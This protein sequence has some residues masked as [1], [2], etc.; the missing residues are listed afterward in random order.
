[1]SEYQHAFQI[2]RLIGADREPGQLVK[3]VREKPFAVLLLDEIEKADPAIF[4]ALLAVLDDGM[5][6]DG[7]GRVTH[8]KNTIIIMTSNL[9]SDRIMEAF[10][11]YDTLPD[12]RKFEVFET[13]KSEVM[14]AL[15]TSLRPEFLNRIDEVVVFHPLQKSQMTQILDILMA[16]IREMLSKQELNLEISKDAGKVLVEHGFD[17][18]FGARPLKRTL[19]RE[20][21]NELAKHLL[22]GDY[23]KGDTV[24]I[25]ADGAV[26]AFGRKT[27]TNGKEVVTKRL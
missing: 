3:E 24:V 15:K 17:P 8:F 7:F 12:K 6:V 14:D 21:I 4:D 18:Q 27:V 13:A 2:D 11:D 26:L 22:G 10:E 5:L 1:M 25:D 9:A 19:Q 20:L 23:V 16:D